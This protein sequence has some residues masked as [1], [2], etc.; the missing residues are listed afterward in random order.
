[1]AL[2]DSQSPVLPT[3]ALSPQLAEGRGGY[4]SRNG[5]ICKRHMIPA[6]FYSHREVIIFQQLGLII[7]IHLVNQNCAS[8]KRRESVHNQ[9][10]QEEPAI[11]YARNVESH[12]LQSLQAGKNIFMPIAHARLRAHCA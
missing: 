5:G 2:Y 8:Y 4:R 10:P 3:D 7:P 11:S 9:R 12:I 6:R 1:M